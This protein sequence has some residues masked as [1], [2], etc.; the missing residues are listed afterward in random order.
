[1]KTEFMPVM[2][3]TMRQIADA[4]TAEDNGGQRVWAAAAR[5]LTA[6]QCAAQFDQVR[7][8]L[9][10]LCGHE[11]DA[12]SK[13]FRAYD[14]ETAA[15]RW[16]NVRRS[17]QV[18]AHWVSGAARTKNGGAIIWG[19]GTAETADLVAELTKTNHADLVKLG[20][21]TAEKRYRAAVKS[22]NGKADGDAENAPDMA[23]T[24][25]AK[26]D[27]LALAIQIAENAAETATAAAA[28][29]E[30]AQFRAASAYGDLVRRITETGGDSKKLRALYVSVL[31][32]ETETETAAAS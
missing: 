27:S 14:A 10:F 19:D 11:Y 25:A 32:A 1:M 18:I 13:T 28:A 4:I 31:N 20:R 2:N 26:C 29:A 15:R 17:V 8:E 6:C 30:S 7:G 23:E 3:G 21:E 24:L 12:D 22:R 16:R 5:I 9:K